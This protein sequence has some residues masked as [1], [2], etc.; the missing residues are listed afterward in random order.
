MGKR[1]EKQ[2]KRMREK[3]EELNKR[4][5]MIQF[6]GERYKKE[7][8]YSCEHCLKI[9]YESEKNGTKGYVTDDELIEASNYKL[10]H[11]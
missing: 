6:L 11:K 2:M 3:E 4:N 8:K 10:I 7:I 1:T 9:A 5:E